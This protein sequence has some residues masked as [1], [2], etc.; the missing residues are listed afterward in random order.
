MRTEQDAGAASSSGE[1]ADDADAATDTQQQQQQQQQ[2]QRGDP[3]IFSALLARK[4]VVA[5]K[6]F[7]YSSRNALSEAVR[8]FDTKALATESGVQPDIQKGK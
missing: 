3:D 7:S 6:M 2:Q 1:G 4:A 8:T 5:S